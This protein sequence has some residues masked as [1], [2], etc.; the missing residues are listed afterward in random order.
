MQVSTSF[1][2]I[3]LLLANFL[4]TVMKYFMEEGFIFDRHLYGG[5]AYS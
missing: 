5:E 2:K 4:L 3:Q 1:Q